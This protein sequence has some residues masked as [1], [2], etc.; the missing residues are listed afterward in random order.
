MNYDLKQIKDMLLDKVEDVCRWL[1]PGGVKS[2]NEWRVGSIE[3]EAGKSLGVNLSTGAWKDFASDAKGG[4][5][6]DLIHAAKGGTKG[7]AI[8]AAKEFLGL[9]DWTPDFKPKGKAYK[10]P[11]KPKCQKPKSEVAAWLA[12][13]GISAQTVAAY[14]IGEAHH[15]ELGAVAVFPYFHGDTLKFIKY[16]PIAHKDKMWTSKDSEPI[17]FGWQVMPK[18]ASSIVI[19]EGEIDSLSFYEQGII[20]LSIPR[21]AGTGAQQDEWIANEWDNLLGMEAIY[22]AYDNDAQGKLALEQV[23]GRLGRHRCFVVDFGKY[24]DANEAHMAGV[25]L[26]ALISTAKSCDPKE[27]RDH[28]NYIEKA[29]AIFAGGGGIE[30]DTLPWVKTHSLVRNRMGEISLWSGFNGSGKS[31]VMGHILVNSIS[32]HRR[33]WCVASMEYRPERLLYRLMRQATGQ[34]CPPQDRIFGRTA[35]MFS[36]C[37]AFVDVQGTAKATKILEI[38]DYAYRRYGYECFLVDSLAKCGFGEDDYNGQKQFIDKLMEFALKNCIQVHIV[39]HSRK[40]SSE[41]DT[42]GK[43]DVKGTGALTDMVDNVFMVWRNK[44]KEENYHKYKD[45]SDCIITC[46]KQRHWDWEG[47]IGLF[48]DRASFQYLEDAGIEPTVYD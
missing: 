30:G 47:K 23:I 25:D 19:S 9:R 38:F 12:S 28:E 48:F 42:P 45:Q 17:L 15:S 26:A 34:D 5:V 36:G 32:R 14:K 33:K 3:G 7:E 13:R 41:D 1:L 20:A 21:G 43:M 8:Q 22:L 31:N 29:A 46:C 10:L 4:D 18:D 40:L 44:P 27:F 16:R 24:K 2:G 11:S 37:L 39:T 35:D 6:I